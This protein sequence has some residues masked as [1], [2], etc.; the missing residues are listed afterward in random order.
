LTGSTADEKPANIVLTMGR[1]GST[2]VQHSIEDHLGERVF[3]VHSITPRLL[4]KQVA[5]KGGLDKAARSALEGLEVAAM[6]VRTSGR[7]KVVTLVRDP[8]ARAYS[9]AFAVLRGDKDP[10]ALAV[11]LDDR[12]AFATWWAGFKDRRAVV[13]FDQ[14]IRDMLG[15]DV[16]ATPF[17]A[18]GW[19]RLHSQRCDLL[20]MKAELDDDAKGRALA[21]FYEVDRMTV[22]RDNARS[23]STAYAPLYERF[24]E[25]A[26]MSDSYRSLLVDSAYNRHFYGD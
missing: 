16:F 14:E 6:L 15:I 21:D 26:K 17:P 20:V 8:I 11:F 23:R 1:V 13:W 12:P 18:R 9:A 19:E 2:A 25:Q 22:V 4:A 24:K 10:D 5:R 3:H 7:V